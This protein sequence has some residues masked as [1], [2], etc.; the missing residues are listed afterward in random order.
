MWK[1]VLGVPFLVGVPTAAV[2]YK[3]RQEALNDPVLQRAMQHIRNDQRI[4]DFCGEE[5]RPGWIITKKVA[6]NNEN[7]VKY[8]MNVKGLSG[9]LNTTVIGDYLQQSE[10]EILEKERSEYYYQKAILDAEALKNTKKEETQ[11]QKKQAAEEYIPVDFDAYS[12]P[13]RS[14]AVKAD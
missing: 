13:D 12:I 4:I 2:G 11:A 6:P 9:K 7:W 5:V 10:L 3:R 14:L 1:Y 8:D